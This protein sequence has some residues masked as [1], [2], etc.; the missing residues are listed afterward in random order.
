MPWKEWQD[1]LVYDSSYQN[2][3]YTVSGS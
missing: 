3:Q 2:W 1:L